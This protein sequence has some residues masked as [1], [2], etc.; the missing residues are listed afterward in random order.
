MVIELRR[1]C[2]TVR[3]PSA[4]AFLAQQLQGFSS[5]SVVRLKAATLAPSHRRRETR[6]CHHRRD[7]ITATSA[8]SV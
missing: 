5:N 8:K 3:S 1:I 6:C 4:Q 7:Q 2:G